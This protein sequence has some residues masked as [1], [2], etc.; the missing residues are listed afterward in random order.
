MNDRKTTLE[1][2]KIYFL[3][4]PPTDQER[5]HRIINRICF[6]YEIE[7]TETPETTQKLLETFQHTPEPPADLLFADF[8]TS[9]QLTSD[10]ISTL[11]ASLPQMRTPLISLSDQATI[12]IHDKDK[13][14]LH[15]SL[16]P[17]QLDKNINEIV[18]SITNFW[19]N[20][21][22]IKQ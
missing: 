17:H 3:Q 10:Q 20:L 14:W 7:R 2:A 19:F 15:V 8:R 12:Q 6:F 13:N 9:S 18:N 21:P 4:I 11:T 5:L 1:E 16:P 22:T